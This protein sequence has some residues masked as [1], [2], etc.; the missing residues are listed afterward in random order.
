MADN[1]DR[2]VVI[3]EV[4]K[5]MEEYDNDMSRIIEETIVKLDETL[6]KSKEYDD[7]DKFKRV[8][9]ETREALVAQLELHSAE[10][11]EQRLMV[12]VAAMDEFVGVTI[13]AD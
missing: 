7:T 8:V 6:E 12:A 4:R 13:T 2:E 5:K 11:R 10:T 1:L 9:A 3:N